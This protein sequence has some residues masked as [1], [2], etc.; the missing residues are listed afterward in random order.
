M[1]ETIVLGANYGNA[2]N[3][4]GAEKGAFLLKRYILEK[5]NVEDG[6][7]L[8]DYSNSSLQALECIEEFTTVTEILR[9]QVYQN[10]IKG[11]KVLTLGGD[12]SIAF[13]TIWGASEYATQKGMNFGVIYVDAHGDINDCKYSISKNIHGMPLAYAI[14]IEDYGFD[15][16]Q[17]YILNPSN[18]LYIGTRSLDP[19]EEEIIKRKKI[20]VISSE[21]I[22]NSKIEEILG[23]ISNFIELNNLQSIHLSIDIDVVDPLYAPGT[24]VPE[25]NGINPSIFLDILKNLFSKSQI[26]SIDLVEF[27]PLLDIEHKTE[28]LCHR[29]INGIRVV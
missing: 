16:L 27:N 13:G 20:K 12:H 5:F 7:N 9:D 4:K 3:V 14:G 23:E 17:R 11:K 2:G 24:G 18:L 10:L 28:H 15:N 19:F 22:N 29:V 1:K 6:L 8:P 26:N 21:K 25:D